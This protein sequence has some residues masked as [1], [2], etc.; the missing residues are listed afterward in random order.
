MKWWSD[1]LS[2]PHAYTDLALPAAKFFS[3]ELHEFS[4]IKAQTS[5]ARKRNDMNEVNVEFVKIRV[6]RG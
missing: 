6:I 2:R 1:G 5:F 3:H 4:R